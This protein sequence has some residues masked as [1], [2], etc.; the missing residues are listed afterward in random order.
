MLMEM[1]E[2]R[3][4]FQPRPV[5]EA[6]PTD[7]GLEFEETWCES[8][9]G[10]RL[11]CWYV[12]GDRRPDL[13]WMWFGGVGGN[14]SLRVGEFAAVRKHTGANIFGFD[15]GGFG[16]SRGKASVRNTA[17][18]ARAALTHVR[19][20]YGADRERTLFVGISMGAA[21]AIRLAA[22]TWPP[23]GMALVA[24]FASLRDMSR[25]L[26][27]RLTWS[28]RLVGNRYNSAALVDRVGCPLLILHGT[29]DQLV[30]FWQGRKLFD[31]AREPK[32]MVAINAAGHMDVGD[33]PEFWDGLCGWVDQVAPP[34]KAAAAAVAAAKPSAY[35][36]GI[37]SLRSQ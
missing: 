12:P 30:P 17:I 32:Q 21:V 20:T 11:Q 18:D 28:G 14:L 24:P 31:A 13:T 34:A 22:E 4:L 10:H 36:D 2:R 1:M 5:C 26:Y 29:D 8:E 15:Y 35:A 27:P 9:G 6:L 23:L 25:L 16:N 37:A 7:L 3:L 19:R 33:Y